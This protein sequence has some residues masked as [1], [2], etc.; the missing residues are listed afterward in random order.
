MN[1]LLAPT[2]AARPGIESA[3]SAEGLNCAAVNSANAA[4]LY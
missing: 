1:T 3:D 2:F 4:V